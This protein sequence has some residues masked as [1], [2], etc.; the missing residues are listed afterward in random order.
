MTNCHNENVQKKKNAH[1]HTKFF[2]HDFYVLTST[3]EIYGSVGLWIWAF[4][5]ALL[6][7]GRF[8]SMWTMC[9]AKRRLHNIT[10]PYVGLA[11]FSHM[12]IF[13]YNYNTFVYKLYSQMMVLTSNTELCTCLFVGTFWLNAKISSHM[14]VP[15]R[16]YLKI[17]AM[18]SIIFLSCHVEE[19]ISSISVNVWS[20]LVQW[21]ERKK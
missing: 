7:E 8:L 19:Q 20:H 10:L 18:Q 2:D 9:A 17:S 14:W 12:L 11:L 15:R 21:C 13:D 16:R 5:S 1:V 6:R 4:T 3:V